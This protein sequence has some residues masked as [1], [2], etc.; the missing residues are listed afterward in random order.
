MIVIILTLVLVFVL[1][2]MPA[3]IFSISDNKIKK[4]WKRNGK[5]VHEKIKIKKRRE[6]KKWSKQTE[7]KKWEITTYK[8]EEINNIVC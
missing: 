7:C 5:M 1:I 3:I 4:N 6:E 8:H 2:L